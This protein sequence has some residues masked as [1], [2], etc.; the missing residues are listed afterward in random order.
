MPRRFSV[1]LAVLSLVSGLGLAS[2]PAGPARDFI[3][4][5]GVDRAAIPALEQ[6]GVVINGISEEGIRAEATETQQARLLSLGYGISIITPRIDELYGRNAETMS[7]DAWYMPYTHFRDTMIT[8]A[9]NNSSFIKLETLGYSVDNRLL[10]AMKFSDN[11]GTNETEPEVHFEANIHGD[12]AITFA[13]FV[14]MVKYLASSYGTDTLVTRLIDEREIWI[15]PLVNPDGYE[16]ETRYN[17]NGVDLN[18]NW[19]WMW[20][21]A[22][23]PGNSPMSEPET[24]ALTAHLWRH[25][26]VLDASYHSG[27]VFLAYPWSY[28]YHDTIPDKPHVHFLS[29]RYCSHNGYA[30]GQGAVHMYPFS[31]A[32]K[33]LEYAWGSLTWSIEIHGHKWP[34]ADSIVPTFNLNRDAMLELWHQVGKGI[35]GTVTDAA[36]GMPVHAQV[37][38]GPG[39][40]PGY[41]CPELGDYHR[42][43]LPGTYSLTFRAP[44]YRDTTVS[45]VV[46]PATG[47]SAVTIG[48]QLTPDDSAPLFGFRVVYNRHVASTSSNHTYPTSALGPHDAQAFKLD[49]GKYICIDMFKPVID[50]PGNDL[51]VYRSGGSAGALVEGA[52]DWTGP[53]TTIGTAVN[54]QTAFDLASVPL[55]SVRFLKLTATG[56]F[57][58]DAVEGVNYT[59]IAEPPGPQSAAPLV[60]R[61]SG[62][63]SAGPV[64]FSLN[65]R[66]DGSPQ[67]LIHDATGRM[68]RQVV[69]TSAR[70]IWDRLDE[71][72]RQAP[73][74]VYFARLSGPGGPAALPVILTR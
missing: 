73:A 22:H 18:R 2:T 49:D 36:T 33:D 46:V 61:L 40:M 24:R 4:I 23:R 47:D 26:V 34:I 39:N 6:S 17:G 62:N 55:D 51:T 52:S 67:L 66:P 63:P 9:E 37:W 57:Y 69:V 31:G 59:G 56:T 3:L 48:T 21:E 71:A 7:H 35:H 72:G 45:P 16:D 43:Y 60:L 8:I 30:Y 64:R 10:L 14:E 68:V 15:V 50:Q 53:W 58:F 41:T 20:G 12:E 74:G 28:T 70:P 11:P 42:F 19:G 38:V 25:P 44:G 5:T 32:A 65:R 29:G 54:A 1:M 27:T 13:V